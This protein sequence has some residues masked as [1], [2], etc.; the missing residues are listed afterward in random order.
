MKDYFCGWQCRVFADLDTK[1]GLRFHNPMTFVP[2]VAISCSINHEPLK[3]NKIEHTVRKPQ[4]WF[5]KFYFGK[6][7]LRIWSFR[8]FQ[9]NEFLATI[10]DFLKVARCLKTTKNVSFEL[11]NFSL[12]TNLCPIKIDL[13]GNTVWPAS[14]TRQIGHFWDSLAI[15]DETFPVSFKHY[16]CVDLT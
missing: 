3:I 2:L 12:F 10:R 9:K 16:E 4:I 7:N 11:S 6:K 15:L 1:R 5:L 8:I 14:K 13:S